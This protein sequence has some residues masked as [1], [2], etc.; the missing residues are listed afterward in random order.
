[1]LRPPQ[2]RRGN[3]LGPGHQWGTVTYLFDI[4]PGLV[5]EP[6]REDDELFQRCLVDAMVLVAV[7]KASE[8]RFEVL[9]KE[10]AIAHTLLGLVA[11]P[12]FHSWDTHAAQR[13]GRRGRSRL[14]RPELLEVLAQAPPTGFKSHVRKPESPTLK[15]ILE[16]PPP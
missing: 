8:K 10:F 7:T 11:D 5:W 12:V 3:R 4:L 16:S 1:M 13:G 14:P 6:L 9:Q 15:P 2:R